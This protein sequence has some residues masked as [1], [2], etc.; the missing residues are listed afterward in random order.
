[1]PVFEVVALVLLI[2]EP[3]IKTVLAALVSNAIELLAE[4][5]I[6]RLNRRFRILRLLRDDVDDAALGIRAVKR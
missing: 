1:M 6:S 2:L 5:A 4:A 3:P